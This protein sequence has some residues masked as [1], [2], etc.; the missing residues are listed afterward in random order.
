MAETAGNPSSLD[1]QQVGFG[2][3]SPLGET[4]IV[5]AT[6]IWI[7]HHSAA[8]IKSEQH[9]DAVGITPLSCLSS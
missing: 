2:Q 7:D 5:A 4:N 6:T 8:L 3:Q 1:A 9:P